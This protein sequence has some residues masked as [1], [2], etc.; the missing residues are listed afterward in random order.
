MDEKM[1]YLY[2][3]TFSVCLSVCVCVQKV[4]AKIKPEFFLV[5]PGTTHTHKSGHRIIIIIITA[6]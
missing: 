2:T 1:A 3:F 6:Y 5:V 4:V